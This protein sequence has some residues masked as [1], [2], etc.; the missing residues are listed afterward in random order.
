VEDPTEAIHDLVARLFWYTPT[1]PPRYYQLSASPHPHHLP[2][3]H[4]SCTSRRTHFQFFTRVVSWSEFKAAFQ[5]E[6]GPQTTYALGRLKAAL[7][8][9][10]QV[11][12]ECADA[13]YRHQFHDVTWR[14]LSL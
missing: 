9:D 7:I 14:P 2:G 5:A 6:Y 1:H 4:F 3:L 12:T 11:H 8:P 10:H 13:S